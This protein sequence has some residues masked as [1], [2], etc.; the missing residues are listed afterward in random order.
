[1]KFQF[2]AMHRQSYPVRAMCAVLGVSPSGYYAWRGRRRSRRSRED[3]ALLAQLQALHQASRQVYGS[4]KLHQALR[5][6]GI[7]CSRKRVIRLMR[8]AGMRA[9]RQRCYKRTTQRNRNHTAAPNQLQQRF[10]APAPNRVWLSDITLIATQE[11]WLYLAVVMDLFSRRIIGW[12]M[13]ERMTEAL[14]QQAL[15]MAIRQRSPLLGNK[16][17]QLLHHSDQGSQYTSRNYQALLAQHGL[18]VSM[19]S[20]GNCYDNAPPESF[21]ASLKTELVYHQRYQ[22]RQQAKTELFAYMEGFYNRQRIHGALGYL[23]PAEYERHWYSTASMM[24]KRI[25]KT[26][27]LHLSLNSVSIEPDQY[28]GESQKR[29]VHESI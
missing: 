23:S 29:V 15:R 5:R 2:I 7:R 9:K 26:Q 10:Q 19:S 17:A 24:N 28:Q 11:G 13:A 22:T 8:Q 6:Q 25:L 12:S 20:T 4:P 18:T 1:M 21:F 27:R 3:E 16:E 14:T